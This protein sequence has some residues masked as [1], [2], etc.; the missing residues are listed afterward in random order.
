MCVTKTSWND[1]LIIN[2]DNTYFNINIKDF[3]IGHWYQQV[4]LWGIRESKIKGWHQF[5][6]I[7]VTIVICFKWLIS[8]ILVHHFWCWLWKQ[9]QISVC[10]KNIMKRYDNE[11][12]T[13]VN[14]HKPSLS[15]GTFLSL[16]LIFSLDV[17]E[18]LAINLN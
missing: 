17:S 6:F 16:S 12:N 13:Y 2:V 18:L 4:W 15:N 8:G 3:F 14:I 5:I 1:M 9:H 7:G 11:D 10:N